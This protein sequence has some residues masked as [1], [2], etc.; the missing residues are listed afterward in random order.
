MP[1]HTYVDDF[2]HSSLYR[3]DRCQ[4]KQRNPEFINSIG[5]CEPCLEILRMS[6]EEYEGYIKTVS[7]WKST[8]NLLPHER[9][10]VWML[11]LDSPDPYT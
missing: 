2:V 9:R 10:M 11:N 5:F 6:T 3:C 8:E 1:Y 7:K 4:V